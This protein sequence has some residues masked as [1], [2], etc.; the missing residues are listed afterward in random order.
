MSGA[1]LTT[2]SRIELSA[3]YEFVR[4]IH[5]KDVLYKVVLASNEEF[6]EGDKVLYIPDRAKLPVRVL[7]ACGF[8][9]YR[10][11]H[12]LLSGVNFDVVRPYY[13]NDDASHYSCGLIISYA[14]LEEAGIKLRENPEALDSQLGITYLEKRNPY[15]FRG[16]E[17]L[18]NINVNKE[19]P[20]ELERCY[21]QFENTDI[22]C[23]EY[24]KGRQFYIVFDKNKP[25]ETA[26]GMFK[27]LHIT[28]QSYRPCR[29]LT[30]SKRN[31]EGNLFCIIA[32]R[33]DF[34][35]K[36]VPFFR[37]YKNLE[38][39]TFNVVARTQA[40]GAKQ[41]EVLKSNDYVVT[42]IFL[43]ENDTG[44]YLSHDER[45]NMCSKLMIRTP[46]LLYTGPYNYDVVHGLANLG[47]SPK[48][49]KYP[50]I[51]I[52]NDKARAVLYSE[53][54]RMRYVYN[55]KN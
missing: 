30:N 35:N 33:N 40:F 23:E 17:Y 55:V 5:L 20:V 21:Q 28:G 43:G 37:L 54:A 36:A 1:L 25:I 15:I 26:H 6:K 27:R 29:F 10:E 32:H 45:D 41:S 47:S 53:A 44:R 39:V 52:R 8:W 49:V 12:G 9:D 31:M 19:L 14:T 42:D 50:G 13:F 4:I 34:T 38:R 7:K 24:V 22:I 16:D 3:K 46:K 51:I 18:F 2:I 11:N 48:R